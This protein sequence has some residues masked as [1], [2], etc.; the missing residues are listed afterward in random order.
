[1]VM[2]AFTVTACAVALFMRAELRARWWAG[3]LAGATQP[4]EQA[5][6]LAAICS[7]RDHARWASAY[8]AGHSD[9]QV[10]QFAVVVLQHAQSSWARQRLEA[11]TRDP[12]PVVRGLAS[13]VN[14][15]ALRSVASAPASSRTEGATP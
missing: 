15:P 14:D 12:D 13:S 9:P 1:M 11:L 6:Y 5:Q 3:R 7:V 8:L 4:A 10:R 2:I